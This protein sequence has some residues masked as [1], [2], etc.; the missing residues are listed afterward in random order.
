[1]RVG[2]YVP[3]NDVKYRKFVNK[4]KFKNTEMQLETQNK[5]D[6]IFQGGN[7]L[8]LGDKPRS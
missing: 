2:D 5:M 3:Q 8:S 7:C 1:M 6:S 4:P